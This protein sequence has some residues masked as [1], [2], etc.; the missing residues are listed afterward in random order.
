MSEEWNPP[1][2][3]SSC[4]LN[5][6]IFAGYEIAWLIFAFAHKSESSIREHSHA[7]IIGWGISC[8]FDLVFRRLKLCEVDRVKRDC[9]SIFSEF[10]A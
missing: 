10:V 6:E 1:I 8:F 4:L 7:F 5:D 9:L 2:Q 3:V